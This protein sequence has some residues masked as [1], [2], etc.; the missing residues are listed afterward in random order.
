MKNIFLTLYILSVFLLKSQ[1]TI[2]NDPVINDYAAVTEID[3]CKNAL[4]L[5]NG[6]ETNFS[7]GEKVLIVQMKGANINTSS[8]IDNGKVTNYLAAGSYEYNYVKSINLGS[9]NGLQFEYNLSHPYSITGKVQVVKIPQ[10]TNVE[11][12]STLTCLPW[13]GNIG[14][15]LIF[16]ASGN[17][18]LQSNIFLDEIGFRGGQYS[19]DND[20]FTQ[21]GGYQGYSCNSGLKC[22]GLKGEGIGSQYDLAKKARGRNAN[23]GGGGN[24]HNAGGGGGANGGNGGNGGENDLNTQFCNGKGGL[25]GEKNIFDNLQNNRILMGVAGGAGDSNN[26]SGTTGGNAGA[27]IILK[28]ESLT[29][30]GF[31]ISANGQNSNASNADGAGGGGAGGT[32]ILEIDNFTDLLTIE[33]KGGKG[34]DITDPGNCPGIGGGGAGGSIW[35]KQSTIP[36]NVNTDFSG[37][38]MGIYT[39]VTCAGLSLGSEDGEEGK[40]FYNYTP[41]VSN[42]PFTQT[43]IKAGT[44]TLICAGDETSIFAN[45]TSSAAP[46]FEWIYEGNSF[47]LEN[48]LIIAPTRKGVNPFVAT[49]TWQVYDQ[50]CIVEETINVS[51]RNPDIIIIASPINPVEVGSPVFLN[52]VVNPTNPNYIY[53]WEQNYVMPNDDRNA[54]V[55]PF[56]TTSFCI[57][58]TDEIS[59]EKTE[60]VEVPVLIPIS[61]APDAFTPN[62]DG[63]NDTYKI[64]PEPQLRQTSFKIYNRWGEMLYSNDSV[65]EWDGRFEGVG[66][67]MDY[68]TWTAEFIHKNTRETSKQTGGFHLIR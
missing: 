34:G 19:N 54:V 60:C 39:S 12:Q 24:D 28:A 15:I 14:G 67:A 40:F 44:D 33:T 68:Y 50:S 17:V 31:K 18:S 6:A 42:Q 29:S 43:K 61:G 8:T 65:F 16:E 10:Y 52:A 63:V 13:D 56:E 64:I 35:I 41:F 20:C 2:I 27:T 47:S 45:I 59:C 58:V 38:N 11:F 3:F 62:N 48:N 21:T 49:A 37:G 5:A 57:T 32:I 4:S 22:G 26:N 55:E 30:N 7:I 66:Q 46:N 25:G 9:I 1:T 36:S 51:V 53:Q 23:G